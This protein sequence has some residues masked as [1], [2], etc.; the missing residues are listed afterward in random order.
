MVKHGHK[1]GQTRTPHGGRTSPTDRGDGSKL[2]ERMPRACLEENPKAESLPTLAWDRG[3]AWSQ[4]K[5]H[6]P[7][8]LP[9]VRFKC[10]KPLEADDFRS[11]LPTPRCPQPYSR[12]GGATRHPCRQRVN[13]LHGACARPDKRTSVLFRLLRSPQATSSALAPGQGGP[14]RVIII[15]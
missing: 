6:W 15:L 1:H 5:K 9:G 3:T 14:I 13:T 11:H 8:A 12:P 7:D 10:T 2:N 4:T